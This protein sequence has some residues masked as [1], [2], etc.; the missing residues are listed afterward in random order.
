MLWQKKV[1]PNCGKSIGQLEPKKKKYGMPLKRCPWCG[2]RYWDKDFSE[3]A[4]R[5]EEDMQKALKLNWVTKSDIDNSKK[6][7][8]DIE[9]AKLLQKAGYQVPE[10]YLSE[11][12]DTQNGIVDF[13]K[14]SIE[15]IKKEKERV[16]IPF[17]GLHKTGYYCL[18]VYLL[19]RFGIIKEKEIRLFLLGANQN[20]LV[21]DPFKIEKEV[22]DLY[23]CFVNEKTDEIKQYVWLV[24]NFVDEKIAMKV[25]DNAVQ[26]VNTR[27]EVCKE[28]MNEAQM[29]VKKE[30]IQS[31]EANKNKKEKQNSKKN[32][33]KK[34]GKRKKSRRRILKY[35][36]A[37]ILLF[38]AFIAIS[39][40]YYKKYTAVLEQNNVLEE[41]INKIE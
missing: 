11:P 19:K 29:E 4:C 1:C 35:K 36:I 9:Y 25:L 30:E 23:N 15:Y 2:S 27:L 17:E 8:E 41:Y 21:Q 31:L 12:L 38:L 20:I 33:C 39:I 5:S 22:M 7:L 32:I 10:K 13:I 34:K 14:Y 26:S 24:E 18:W 3:I 37:F 6:R 16:N 28:R 40:I